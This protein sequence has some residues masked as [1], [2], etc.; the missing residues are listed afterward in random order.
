MLIIVPI[1]EGSCENFMRAKC[2]AWCQVHCRSIV[3]AYP[4]IYG[5]HAPY[6][7]VGQNKLLYGLN[8]LYAVVMQILV[9][10]VLNNSLYT[11]ECSYFDTKIFDVCDI[12]ISKT[13]WTEYMDVKFWVQL[14]HVAYISSLCMFRSLLVSYISAI[15]KK[16]VS[17]IIFFSSHI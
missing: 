11:L 1:T 17:H 15:Q 10:A 7:I 9:S 3:H 2:L 12:L 4:F 5:T 16:H 14:Q 6:A 8:A 13:C